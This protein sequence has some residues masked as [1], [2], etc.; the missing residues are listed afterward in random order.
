MNI[1]Y[2]KQLV[3]VNLKMMDI[4]SNQLIIIMDSWK[5]NKELMKTNFQK[6]P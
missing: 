6:K 5:K 1:A 3:I 2:N 4:R